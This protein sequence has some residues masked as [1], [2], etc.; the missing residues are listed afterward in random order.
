M[1]IDDRR[2][3]T[4]VQRVKQLTQELED[5]KRE[6]RT[7]LPGAARDGRIQFVDDNDDV[8]VRIGQLVGA[9]G[10]GTRWGFEGVFQP[11]NADWP[12]GFPFLRVSDDGAEFPYANT[13]WDV[14]T[15]ISV[16]SGTF[17]DIYTTAIGL[18]EHV[19]VSAYIRV[20]TPV[21][22]TGE[23]RLANTTTGTFSPTV[24]VPSDTNAYLLV[25]AWA[26]GAALWTGPIAFSVQARRTTGAGNV[27]VYKTLYGLTYLPR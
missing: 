18:I 2:N 20:L 4:L 13:A 19:D 6:V 22:T 15:A 1:S 3:D 26:H 12:G 25:P 24:T 7:R 11:G 21:G 14:E 27:D 10:A 9:G 8:R 5:L 16:T 17:A 23:I